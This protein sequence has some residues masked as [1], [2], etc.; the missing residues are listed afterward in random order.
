MK[1]AA[2]VQLNRLRE[3]RD[4]DVRVVEYR[5]D[6]GAVAQVQDVSRPVTAETI[7]V[8]MTIL[9]NGKIACDSSGCE[10]VA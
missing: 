10:A 7:P 9:P 4:L 1:F 2:L 5:A 3:R 8:R 6:G